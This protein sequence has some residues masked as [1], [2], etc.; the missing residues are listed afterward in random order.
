MNQQ[1]RRYTDKRKATIIVECIWDEGFLASKAQQAMIYQVQTYI[2]K[3]VFTPAKIFKEMDLAGFKL[4]L[5]GIEVLRRIDCDQRYSR[6]FL[7]SKSSILWAARKV[8]LHADDLCP[9]MMIGR[10]Y[11]DDVDT[12]NDDD[13]GE[14]FEFD[15]YKTTKTLFV[16]IDGRCKASTC[17]GRSYL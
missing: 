10:A 15:I 13:F 12:A 2:W 14:G 7:P 3:K 6:G 5:A 17:R 11:S 16:W 8:E 9:F 1:L 4:S